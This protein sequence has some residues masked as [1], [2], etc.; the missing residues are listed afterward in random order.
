MKLTKKKG[1]LP[2]LLCL[3]LFAGQFSRQTFAA[4]VWPD[5][6]SI[7][8]EGGILLDGNSGAVLYAKN[9]FRPALPR[10]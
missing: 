4:P 2:F 6:P 9:I 1:F 3:A 5:G 10:S 7:S 8:A